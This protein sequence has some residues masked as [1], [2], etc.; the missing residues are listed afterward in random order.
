MMKNIKKRADNGQISVGLNISL[1]DPTI[2]EM[3]ARVGYDFV[4][5]DCEHTLFENSAIINMIRVGRLL[6]MPVQLRVPNL[7]QASSLLDLGASALMIPHVGSREMAE[8]AAKIVKYA[9]YGE[10]GM[11]SFARVL[12]YGHYQ[13]KDYY[14]WANDVVCLIIQIEDKDGLDNIDDILSVPGI[15]MVASGKTDLSQ[16]LGI[17]GQN[18]HPD[19]LAAEELIIR[20]ALEYGKHPTMLVKNPE[21][22]KA[23]KEMGVRC[24]SIGRDE[25]LLLEG[26]KNTL[27][28]YREE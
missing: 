17:P 16:A 7:G 6:D 3:A 24:F 13:F 1:C 10:R 26:M 22:M 8:E 14:K 25:A 27:E 4:R 5:L 12:G 9:P 18:T 15:D 19:V 21:R 2:V 28:A 11:S 23:L 20:K